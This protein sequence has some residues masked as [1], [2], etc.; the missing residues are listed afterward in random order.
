MPNDRFYTPEALTEGVN[1]SLPE[2]ESHHLIRVMR[3][4]LHEEVEVINGQGKLAHARVTEIQK[5]H[6]VLEILTVHTTPPPAQEVIIAQAIPRLNRLDTIVEKGTEL[7]M[8]QLWLFPGQRSEK[9]ELSAQ[10]QQRVHMQ[11]VAA[12]KQCGRMYLPSLQLKPALNRWDGVS[13]PAFFGDISPEAPLFQI[14]DK[15]SLIFFIGPEAGFAR[16]EENTLRQLNAKGVKLHPNILR[17]DTAPLVVL[18]LVSYWNQTP[19]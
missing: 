14:S 2:D 15:T 10:Q 7:G 12:T 11:M 16:E 9:K 4:Q 6:V 13:H 1:V 17:T 5:K 8:T 19:T 18:S 3:V